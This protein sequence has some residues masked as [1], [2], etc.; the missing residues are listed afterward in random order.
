[1]I[2]FKLIKDPCFIYKL[3]EVLAPYEKIQRLQTTPIHLFEHLDHAA[4]WPDYRCIVHFGDD[5]PH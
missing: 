3:R 5:Y 4:T 1:M 2:H